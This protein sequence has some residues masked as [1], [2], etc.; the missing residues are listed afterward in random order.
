MAKLQWAKLTKFIRPS[1]TD[2]P[3]DRRKSSIPYA[4]PSNRTPKA[5]AIMARPAC[6]CRCWCPSPAAIR[7]PLQPGLQKCQDL[8]PGIGAEATGIERIG[9]PEM[10]GTGDNDSPRN[11][12]RL[13]ESGQK[14]GGL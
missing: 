11:E 8:R 4:R 2:N 5:E 13:L 3:T 10:S 12:L 1:V 14:C 9:D 7:R 6:E